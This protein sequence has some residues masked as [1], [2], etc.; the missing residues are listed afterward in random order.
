MLLYW[1]RERE[2][3]GTL[4]VSRQA[5]GGKNTMAKFK[6]REKLYFLKHRILR[7]KGKLILCD[8]SLKQFEPQSNNAGELNAFMLTEVHQI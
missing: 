8:V 2:K 6:E 7:V 4:K 5:R 1:E 3:I